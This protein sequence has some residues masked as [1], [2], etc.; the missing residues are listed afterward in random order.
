VK[1]ALAAIRATHEAFADHTVRA[2][3]LSRDPLRFVRMFAS[4]PEQE[5]V[6]LC[7]ALLAFGNVTVI[8]QKLHE[9][10]FTRLGARPHHSVTTWTAARLRASLKSYRHRTFV[11]D[12][13]ARLL[14]GAAKIQARDGGLFVGLSR[15]FYGQKSRSLK[16]ALAQWTDE[17]RTVSFG[18]ELSRTAKHLLPDVHGPSACKR[19]VLLCRWIS[20]P[21][22]GIDLGWNIL[23]PDSLLIPMDV[24]VHRVSRALG[25]TAERTASWKC[26]EQVTAALRKLDPD[27]PVKYDFALCHTEIGKRYSAVS[28]PGEPVAPP[29]LK[30]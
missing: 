20:R 28:L 1:A 9:L 7:A 16:P 17:L 2:Q 13:I 25:L 11:G 19:W 18:H 3:A 8:G 27:D 24:H 21:D 10:L 29:G 14:L 30:R 23:P 22:D 15:A 6:A 4:R 26:A 12:D 5:L